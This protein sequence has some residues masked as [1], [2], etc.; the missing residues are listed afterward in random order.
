MDRKE[1]D[2]KD[3][4]DIISLL[5]TGTSPRNIAVRFHYTQRALQNYI[6][7]HNLIR[8]YNLARKHQRE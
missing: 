2:T 5:K 4:Q 1:I 3:H 8:F 6:K 7:Q